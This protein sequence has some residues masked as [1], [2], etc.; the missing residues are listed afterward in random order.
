MANDAT[1][2]P[3]DGM[4]VAT[5]F[6]AISQFALDAEG[7]RRLADHRTHQPVAPSELLIKRGWA[8]RAASLPVAEDKDA[9][10]AYVDGDVLVT[11]GIPEGKLLAKSGAVLGQAMQVALD[12]ADPGMGTQG[13]EA[14]NVGDVDLDVAIVD[15]EL[16]LARDTQDADVAVHALD[17]QIRVIGHLDVEIYRQLGF[18]SE[19]PPQAA[20]WIPGAQVHLLVLTGELDLD[21]LEKGFRPCLRAAPNGLFGFNFHTKLIPTFNVEVARA[22][23]DRQGPIGKKA[24]GVPSGLCKLIGARRAG[25]ATE[26]AEKG[27]SVNDD[28]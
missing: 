16:L 25:R 7:W 2:A 21:A 4:P 23:V 24:R 6:S 14:I 9:A 8:R 18:A 17:L 12:V 19:R 28:A 5:S 15:E 13:A 3:P 10:Q 22:R 11:C 20:S 26:D 27:R 1:Y